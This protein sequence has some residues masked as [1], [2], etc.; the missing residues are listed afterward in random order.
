MRY[1]DC[2]GSFK[3][4]NESCPFRVEF[5]VVNRTKVNKDKDGTTTCGICGRKTEYVP[6]PGRRYVRK[7]K[8]SI[9]VFHWG[10]HTCPVISKPEK[11]TTKIREMLEENPKLT[12]SEIQSSFI[13]ASLRKGGD[14]NE[15]EKAA[16]R[17]VDKKWIANEKENIKRETRPYGENFEAVVTFKLYCDN[18]DELLIHKVNDRRGN[19]DFPSFVFKT[20]KERMKIALNMDREGEHFMREEYCYFDGKVK[21]C[22]NFVTLTASTYHPIL[23]KQIPLAIMETEKEDSENIELF[24]TLFNTSIK[25][26]AGDNTVFFN[27]TGWCT[28]MAGANMNGIERVFGKDALSRIKSCEFHFKE[29]RNKMARKLGGTVGD[30]F[31]VLCQN[32]L[33]CNLQES[34][35]VAKDALEEFIDENSDRQFLKSWLTWWDSRRCFIFSAFSPKCGPKMNLAEVVHAG[36]ANRDNRNLSLLDVAQIDVKDSVLLKAELKAIEQG[37]SKP[38]GR[39][40]AFH[41]KRARDHRRELQKA[42]Q[43]GKEVGS[44]AA[45]LEVDPQSG[46]FPPEDKPK[47]GRKRTKNCNPQKKPTARSEYSDPILTEKFSTTLS[48]PPT[49]SQPRGS[50]L[51][52]EAENGQL[53]SQGQSSQP[54][55]Q[56]QN[57]RLLSQGQSSQLLLQAQNS[58]LLSQVASSQS[59][60]QAHTSQVLPQVP[61]SQSLSQVQTSQPM[62]PQINQLLRMPQPENQ[63]FCQL[64]RQPL[65]HTCTATSQASQSTP[66]VNYAGIHP[67]HPVQTH[68]LGG[69][70]HSG[71]SH[72]S[73]KLWNCL[74]K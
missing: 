23:K 61:S 20:S 57:S 3:C 33:E 50:E 25:K 44:L 59:L 10:N 69:N 18:Q 16:N 13:M 14:W 39:G 58:Q 46:Y 64:P 68:P 66:V 17:L 12:P 38:V 26:A 24:W 19:P 34:Y 1:A 5:G 65:L 4:T 30:E 47:R 32:L 43:L 29:S 41:E 56:E 15:V 36:W 48:R 73:M 63:R 72:T 74:K 55:S 7:G 28:D 11:P 9:K 2:Q 45:G 62:L 27:P 6:C 54:L 71:F 49:L 35:L 52:L 40:P 53:L 60:S 21:R 51:R 31:K 42:V 70:W 22:R 67:Y 8:K 37:S